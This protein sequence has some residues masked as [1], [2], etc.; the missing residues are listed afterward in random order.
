MKI[1]RFDQQA[2]KFFIYSL[3]ALSFGLPILIPYWHSVLV[4]SVIVCWLFVRKPSGFIS[5]IKSERKMIMIFSGIFLINILGLSYTKNMGYGLSI[6][7]GLVPLLVLP[8]IILTSQ[9]QISIT[10]ARNIIIA[11]IA[12]V[13]TLNL[14]TLVFISYDFWD[15]KRLEANLLVANNSVLNVHP[16]FLSLH[17]SF[18]FF[19]IADSYFPLPITDRNKLG[20]ILFSS[21]VLAVYL[22]W[23]NS[24]VGIFG[25]LMAFIFYVFYRFRNVKRVYGSIVFVL[26]IVFLLMIPFSRSRFLEAPIMLIN[27]PS[28]IEHRSSVTRNFSYRGDI[29]RCCLDII[30]GPELLY[31]YGTGDFKDV[32]QECY[33]RKNYSWLS[34]EQLD[35]QNEYFAEI[36]RNGLL[37][38]LLFLS[39][40]VVPFSYAMEFKSPLFAVFIILFGI[41][42]LFENVFNSQKGV[43]F[44]ALFCPLLYIYTKQNWKEKSARPI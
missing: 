3:Y 4:A 9:S 25:F 33:N 30:K 32:L 10:V 19:F 23:I 44:F 5:Q 17:I 37:G 12:G 43:T 2:D 24:R 6:I 1:K 13:L 21:I 22:V 31:G 38:L 35:S 29:Y 20:W 40:L 11:F 7:E 28:G 39:V 26:F 15:P 27:Q 42:A 8:V 18:G 34:E 41:T 36:H 14:A 16:I